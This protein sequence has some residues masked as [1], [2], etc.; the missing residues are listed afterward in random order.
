VQWLYIDH[1][2]YRLLP[3]IGMNSA[4]YTLARTG[5]AAAKRLITG[6][7]DFD[8]IDAHYFYPDGVA[9]PEAGVLMDDRSADGIVRAIARLRH[10][11][12]ARRA[13]R[14]YAE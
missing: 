5:L 11:L 10:A 4:P 3:K 13:T 6:G 9:A 1:P 8:L 2:R 7:Y 14:A 12:P